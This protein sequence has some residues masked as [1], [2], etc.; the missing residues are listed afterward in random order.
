MST[1]LCYNCK[2]FGHYTSNCSKTFCNY[3]KKAGHIIKECPTQKFAIAY[4]VS[5]D[6]SNA[7]NCV[8]TTP[9]TLN[10]VTPSQSF[11]LK[12]VQQ[13]IG[14]T[15]LLFASQANLSQ[16]LS[17]CILILESP[18]YD[19]HCCPPFPCATVLWYLRIH[20]ANSSSLPI[21]ATGDLSPTIKDVFVSPSLITNLFIYRSIGWKWLQSRIF[22]IWLCCA[23][24]S[25][26]ADDRDRT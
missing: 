1:V 14:N 18:S 22:S 7:P 23:K 2:G 10:V 25:I 6:P 20:T 12:M 3:Y 5:V 17:H 8:E 19:K 13:M 9:S 26:W 21:T 11:T 16:L 24:S 4:H 15:S